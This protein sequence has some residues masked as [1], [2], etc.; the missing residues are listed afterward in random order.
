MH[1]YLRQTGSTRYC[2]A[3]FVDSFGGTGQVKP[4]EWKRLVK[5]QGNGC[6]T[7][8]PNV[9]GFATLVMRLK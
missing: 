4:G 6:L 9:R 2:L 1:N 7:D 5:A 3:G 8:M